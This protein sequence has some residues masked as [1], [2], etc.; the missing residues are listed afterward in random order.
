MFQKYFFN[1]QTINDIMWNIHWRRS[2]IQEHEIANDHLIHIWY[3]KIGGLKKAY[4]PRNIIA[5]NKKDYQKQYHRTE[6]FKAYR[7]VYA[8]KARAEQK[9]KYG[10]NL[11]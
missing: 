11:W 3:S 2:D 10:C 4:F 6:K 7:R 9:R 8:R 1:P 5:Q